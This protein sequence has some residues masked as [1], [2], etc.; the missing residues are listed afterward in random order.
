MK[1]LVLVVMSTL[2]IAC[3]LSPI[4]NK[5]TGESIDL[6]RN[7][8]KITII[9]NGDKNLSVTVVTKSGQK[10]KGIFKYVSSSTGI[11]LITTPS[12]TYHGKFSPGTADCKEAL[13]ENSSMEISLEH[14][15][16]LS[17]FG[18]LSDEYVAVCKEL[19]GLICLPENNFR[20]D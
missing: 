6:L 4:N 10:C 9:P 18:G 19:D 1:G 7:N 16:S 13:G 17:T 5:R 8:E 11:P 3:S 20:L 14:G 2:M 15:A 12:N